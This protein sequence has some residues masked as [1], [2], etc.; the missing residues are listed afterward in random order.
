VKSKLEPYYKFNRG[1]LQ[2]DID[3]LMTK[4]V[5]VMAGDHGVVEEEG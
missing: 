5:I 2:V 4:M 1:G 3:Q